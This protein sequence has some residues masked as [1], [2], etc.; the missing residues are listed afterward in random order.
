MLL[1]WAVTKLPFHMQKHVPSGIGTLGPG[2]GR[3]FRLFPSV[4][5]YTV[6]FM[7]YL[8]NYSTMQGTRIWRGKCH[9][10]ASILPSELHTLYRKVP[11]TPKTISYGTLHNIWVPVALTSVVYILATPLYVPQ[12]PSF[13]QSGDWLA[14]CTMTHTIHKRVVLAYTWM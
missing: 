12:T 10:I 9:L 5:Q 8:D 3:L 2:W 7:N 13:W 4:H 14:L 6:L 11:N 1:K